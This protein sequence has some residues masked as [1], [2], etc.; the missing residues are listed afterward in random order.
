MKK[1]FLLPMLLAAATLLTACGAAGAGTASSAQSAPAAAQVL[2]AEEAHTRMAGGG[3]VIVDVRTAEEYAEAHIPGA[4]L[5]PNEDIGDT[6]P[7][8]L[9]VLDA[10]LLIY[11]RS[12]NRSAQ[13]AKKLTALG[14]TNVYDFGGIRD[15]PYDTESGAWTEP[16]KAGTLA[17][18][19]TW[20][21]AGVPVDESIFAG[22]QLT[23][24]NVWATYCGYCLQ[25]MPDLNQLAKDYA[26][27]GVQIVGIVSDVPQDDGGT[28][29]MT[30]LKTARELAEKTGVTYRSLLISPDLVSA[31]LGSI[32]SVPT[33]FFVDGDGKLVG[34]IYP[35]ARSAAKWAAIVDETLAEAAA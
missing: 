31:G 12:G 10:E 3:A 7:A 18:F 19:T 6:R 24:V 8:S 1:T 26:G 4:I 30:R 2:T 34:Q 5:L 13:A 28:F 17:S 16:D 35:G 21:L 15:W 20:D 29:D 27:K 9:P 23:M 11:C 32:N 22:H 33:T 25:E 14:Y